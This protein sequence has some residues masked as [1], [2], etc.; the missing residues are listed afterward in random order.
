MELGDVARKLDV[1]RAHCDSEGRDYDSIQK[2]ACYV[3][4]VLE[5][6]DQFVRDTEQL[7]AWASPC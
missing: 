1:L 5:D 4:P 2:R 7:G 6:S 3:R